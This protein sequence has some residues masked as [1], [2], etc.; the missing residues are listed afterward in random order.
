MKIQSKDYSNRMI[1]YT[2]KKAMVLIGV[3]ICE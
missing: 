2:D 1:E 3:A